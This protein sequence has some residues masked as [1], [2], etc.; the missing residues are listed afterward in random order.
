MNIPA[1]PS[2]AN[3]IRPLRPNTAPSSR[4]T[5]IAP[6]TS[7][8]THGTTTTK[9]LMAS[10]RSSM[11]SAATTTTAAGVSSPRPNTAGRSTVPAIV[12]RLSA[13][14]IDALL[15]A[16][17]AAYHD[18][19]HDALEEHGEDFNEWV[20][21]YSPRPHPPEDP[22]A[23]SAMHTATCSHYS[24]ASHPSQR[25]APRW[26]R[27]R[28]KRGTNLTERNRPLAPGTTPRVAPPDLAHTCGGMGS[29][30]PVRPRPTAA[31][32]FFEGDRFTSITQ[33]LRMRTART[34][35]ALRN[36]DADME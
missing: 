15:P 2:T 30:L 29:V 5:P 16:L 10:S 13:D 25:S 26:M 35:M 21:T 28:T 14:D 34:R 12:P 33:F 18:S 8:P 6:Q 4:P 36:K 24:G 7:A 3:R 22:T 19:W 11:R 23:R 27:S 31:E 32:N 1:R 20:R 9:R 17:A